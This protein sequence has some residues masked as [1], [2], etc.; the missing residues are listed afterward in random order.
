MFAFFEQRIRPTALPGSA[1]PAGLLAFYWHCIRQTRGLY[2]TMFV[3]GLAVASVDTQIPLFIGRLAT[4]M[5]AGDRAAAF[6]AALPTLLGML[7]VVLPL[8]FHEVERGSIRIDGHDLRRLTQESLRG[9]IGMVTQGTSLLHRSIP[10]N[11]ADG[12]PGATQAQ[13][14]AAAKRAQAHDFILALQDWTGRTDCEA[15]A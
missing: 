14:E 3:T 10:A 6:S 9:A 1:P 13:I 7:A 4:P 11:I 15:Q 2:A 5:Q 8:R 12:H